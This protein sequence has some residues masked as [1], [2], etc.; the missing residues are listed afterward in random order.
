MR[1]KFPSHLAICSPLLQSNLETSLHH[2]AHHRRTG[3]SVVDSVASLGKP[4]AVNSQYGYW[5]KVTVVRLCPSARVEPGVLFPATVTGPAESSGAGSRSSKDTQ[6][7]A[8]TPVVPTLPLAGNGEVP[9]KP[10]PASVP[11]T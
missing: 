2:A 10:P 9:V 5:A 3:E 1:L 8:T 6:P 4:G 7:A 11:G